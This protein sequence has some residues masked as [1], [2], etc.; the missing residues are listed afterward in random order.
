MYVHSIPIVAILV[1][2]VYL[3]DNKL[4][5]SSKRVST[6]EEKNYLSSYSV[7]SKGE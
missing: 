3:I 7:K 2:R 5:E 4:A 1:L 6:T